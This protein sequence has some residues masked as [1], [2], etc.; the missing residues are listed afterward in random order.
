MDEETPVAAIVSNRIYI[1]VWLC[2]LVLT[3]VTVTVAKL[4]LTVYPII[5]AIAIATI[6]AW[7]VV[8]FFL[9]LRE[10]PWVLKIMLF[11]AIF[12]L[13]LLILLTFADTWFRYG[14]G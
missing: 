11:I 4:H 6:K 9:Q 5:P 12:A 13:T 7:L 1:I 3:A 8:N 14:L 10:E 2:L